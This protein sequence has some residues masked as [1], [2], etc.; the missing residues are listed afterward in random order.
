MKV[1]IDIPDPPYG[2]VF[3][4]IRKAQAGEMALLDDGRWSKCQ[5]SGTVYRYPIAVKAKP[6]WEPSPELVAVL[7]PGWIAK[8][9]TGQWFWYREKPRKLSY[10]W[11]GTTAFGLRIINSKLLP[12]DSTPWDQSCF[13]IGDPQE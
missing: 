10:F 9:S 12:P 13:K 6:L 11:E 5:Y 3:D 4:G 7:Q 1:E 2:W 8:D